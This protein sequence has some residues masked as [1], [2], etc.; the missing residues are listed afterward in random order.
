MQEEGK[1]KRQ[2]AAPAG[3]SDDSV[4]ALQAQW[5]VM[6]AGC[7]FPITCQKFEPTHWQPVNVYYSMHSPSIS[8]VDYL[9]RLALHCDFSYPCLIL[10][11]VYVRR[12]QK[13]FPS[14]ALNSLCAHRLCLSTLLCAT[15]FWDDK[16]FKN[17]RWARA[18]GGTNQR[19]LSFL[20][21]TFVF[22]V[23][24]TVTTLVFFFCVF[25]V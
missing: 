20:L 8:L 16:V 10:A 6:A 12:L 5:T 22:S 9:K 3:R 2:E 17:D 13:Q 19:A 15:K 14:L 23:Y 7:V 18:G 1:H 24:S 25:V 21:C 11:M 4:L